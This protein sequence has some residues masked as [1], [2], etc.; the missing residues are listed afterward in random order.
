MVTTAQVNANQKNAQLSTGPKSEEG[1]EIVSKNALKH[2]ILSEE[3]V[4]SSKEVAE[5]QEKYDDLRQKFISDLEP[6]GMVEEMLVDRIVSTYW[7]LR[8]V[9]VSEKGIIQKQTANLSFNN[10]IERVKKAEEYRDS[11]LLSSFGDKLLNSVSAIW[12]EDKL[13]DLKKTIENMGYLPDI[14]LQTYI[15]MKNI[16]RNE[17]SLRYTYFFNDIALGKIEGEEKEKGKK[18]LLFLI[19]KDLEQANISIEVAQKLEEADDD[20]KSLVNHIPQSDT[21]E[22]ISRYET[23]LENQLYRALNH[24]L[25][26]QTLRKG[27]RVLSY[28]TTDIEGIES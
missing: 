23:A 3:V 1:K 15:Q 14:E 10:S 5:S 20:N 9:I 18:A 26:V 11:P 17:E 28:K 7:R 4:I 6:V 8:R 21:A 22:K 16:F 2:G 27:G 12:T 25:K 19:E 24:L 13:Q